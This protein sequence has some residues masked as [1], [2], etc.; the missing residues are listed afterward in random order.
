MQ[1][2]HPH[3]LLHTGT[4]L[5]TNWRT[6]DLSLRVFVVVVD[7][8]D[9]MHSGHILVLSVSSVRVLCACDFVCVRWVVLNASMRCVCVCFVCVWKIER[10]NQQDLTLQTRKFAEPK[11]S[12]P[13]HCTPPR[14]ECSICSRT[15]CV[16]HLVEIDATA[17]DTFRILSHTNVLF[18]AGGTSVTAGDIFRGSARVPSAVRGHPEDSGRNAAR[19]VSTE[20]THV[21]YHIIIPFHYLYEHI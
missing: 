8:T 9:C 15:T 16:L 10:Q 21:I 13:N 18:R 12:S 19:E 7:R 5:G 6:Y 14:W 4:L 1:H 3:K 11:R 17:C 20:P 2:K